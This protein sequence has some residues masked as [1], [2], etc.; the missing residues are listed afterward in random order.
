MI[1]YTLRD[2]V[3]RG[4]V[5]TVILGAGASIALQKAN[6]I[7]NNKELPSML[8]FVEKVN[9]IPILE[10]HN[11]DDYNINFEDLYSRL[12]IEKDKHNVLLKELE[13]HIRDWFIDLELSDK[14]T[15]Y[16]YLILGLRNKDC[17][18]TFNW[19]PLLLQAM[20]RCKKHVDTLPEILFLHGEVT[21]TVDY[22]NKRVTT[23]DQ[24]PDLTPGPILFPVKEKDY[25]S[26]EV[27]AQ[28]WNIFLEYLKISKMVTVF[29]YSAPKTDI[30]AIDTM[31]SAWGDVDERNFEQ[32]EFIDIKS[33]DEILESWKD[34]VHTHHFHCIDNFFDSS[35]GYHPRRTGEDYF[36][37]NIEAIPTDILTAPRDCSFEDL[38][39]WHKVLVEIENRVLQN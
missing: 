25:K 12:W 1:D 27:I 14:P 39:N 4:C 3:Q 8:N 5:H 18:A 7:K 9:L 36:T 24:R 32:F 33:E 28:F 17:I 15:I 10:K 11:I 29:G 38:I 26:N 20:R 34:F 6:G 37:R 21:F 16:D 2:K 13:T 35:I 31:K 19:D 23:L 30:I 22:K